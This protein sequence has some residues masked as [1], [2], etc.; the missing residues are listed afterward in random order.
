MQVTPADGCALAV[1]AVPCDAGQN[2]AAALRLALGK[3]VREF[4]FGG[5]LYVHIG[6]RRP[7]VSWHDAE[8]I[9]AR[10]SPL[11]VLAA[12]SA[13]ERQYRM[14]NYLE[15][16]PLARL[17]M[18]RFVPFAWSLGELANGDDDC[19]PL[20]AAMH[21]WGARAGRTI[22]LQDHANGPAFLTLF[23]TEATAARAAERDAEL[24]WAGVRLHE[25]AR[26]ATM[27]LPATTN[28]TL[29][30]MNVLRFAALGHTE[31][32]TAQMLTLSRRG[33]QFHLMRAMEKLNAPNKIAAAV[34]A[35][36]AG[37][38]SI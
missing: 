1:S 16:D 36:N 6:H 34:R 27:Q 35:V 8:A 10:P 19:Q 18:E 31:V 12:G 24:L 23:G 4:E 26:A 14:R 2:P 25:A 28:L 30:E 38:I 13:D 9:S 33:V 15:I 5:G 22:P 21:G 11:R 29:R 20:V 17:A 32:E 7:G 37:L 3:L